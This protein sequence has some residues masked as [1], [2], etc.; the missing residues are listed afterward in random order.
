MGSHAG[1]FF[2]EGENSTASDLFS[3]PVLTNWDERDHA[4][5]IRTEQ[6]R[7]RSRMLEAS[8]RSNARIAAK[9]YVE[10][11]T[12][13]KHYFPRSICRLVRGCIGMPPGPHFSRQAR[14]QA[15]PSRPTCK[16]GPVALRHRRIGRI[17]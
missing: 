3:N 15:E 10:V 5:H 4:E 2:A 14:S 13:R 6:K 11:L 1:I 7:N 17:Q 12:R 9:M 8:V 16:S